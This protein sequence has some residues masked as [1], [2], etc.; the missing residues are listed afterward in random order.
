MTQ[1]AY[2][3]TDCDATTVVISRHVHDMCA[4][5]RL[6]RQW[7]LHSNRAFN[8]VQLWACLGR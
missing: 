1:L 3:W 8:I 6:P 2:Q 5:M 7:W 4:I